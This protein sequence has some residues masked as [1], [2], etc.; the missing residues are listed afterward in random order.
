[1]PACVAIFLPPMDTT[2]RRL[3]PAG[4]TLP[5]T[6][7]VRP[8]RSSRRL[9]RTLVFERTV[10]RLEPVSPSTGSAGIAAGSSE[11]GAA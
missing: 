11:A 6:S 5:R 9:I 1:M 2:T 3:A 8:T 4:V 7:T 10:T